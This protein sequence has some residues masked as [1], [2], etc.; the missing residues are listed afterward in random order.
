MKN[1]LVLPEYIRKNLDKYKYV[2]IACCVG[3]LLAMQPGKSAPEA[4]QAGSDSLSPP[5]AEEIQAAEDR[6]AGL[7]GQY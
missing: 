1:K 2:L 6:L 7:L 3:L 4:Q 5:G